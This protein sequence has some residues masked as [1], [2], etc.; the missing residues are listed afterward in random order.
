MRP[1]ITN[2]V[3]VQSVVNQIEYRI[4]VYTECIKSIMVEKQVNY[5]EAKLILTFRLNKNANRTNR[6]TEVVENVHQ[7]KDYC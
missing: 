2:K 1:R 6:Y 4:K 7:S 3:D 5:K